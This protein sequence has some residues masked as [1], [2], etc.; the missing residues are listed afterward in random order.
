M[1]ILIALGGNA[2]LRRGEAPDAAP[3][4]AHIVAAAPA[5]ALLAN[6]HRVVITH[7]NGPQV[8]LLALESAN[9]DALLRPYPLDALVAETQG[10]IGYW[11]QRQRFA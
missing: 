8:G 11:L 4:L 3:Q 1:L 7:G 6:Q 10:L 5:L 2:L 9:D